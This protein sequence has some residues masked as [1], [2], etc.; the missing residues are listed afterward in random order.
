MTKTILT[1]FTVLVAGSALA[2]AD[3]ISILDGSFTNWTL[4]SSSNIFGSAVLEASGGNPG[5]M[6]QVTTSTGDAGN[7]ASDTVFATDNNFS[8]NSALSGNFQL[9]LDVLNSVSVFGESQEL[10]LLVSQVVGAASVIYLD[11]LGPTGVNA[12]WTTLTFN[13][14]LNPSNFTRASFT[15]PVTP[16]FSGATATSFGFAVFAQESSTI[17]ND[18]DNF[19]LTANQSAAPEPSTI[20]LFGCGG[21]LVAF[22]KA[23]SLLLTCR[24]RLDSSHPSHYQAFA[25]SCTRRFIVRT[26][27]SSA[28]SRIDP[29]LLARNDPGIL[30]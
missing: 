5:S 30:N 8:T 27:S 17:V 15:G 22:G 3:P 7:P 18:F 11:P 2:T 21:L 23:V 29:P 24:T 13:G 28:L 6:L 19:N 16:D 25:G 9:Q 10:E 20:M 1:A 4:A 14:A 26:L 12:S